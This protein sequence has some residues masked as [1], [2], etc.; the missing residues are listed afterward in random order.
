MRKTLSLCLVIGALSVIGIGILIPRS[1]RTRGSDSASANTK[2]QSAVNLG[3]SETQPIL[4]S[5]RKIA[6]RA[7]RSDTAFP[8]GLPETALPVSPHEELLTLM[9]A[10]RTRPD[11]EQLSSAFK[12]KLSELSVSERADIL[13]KV[14]KIV[15]ERDLDQGLKFLQGLEEFRDRHHFVKAVVEAVAQRDTLRA[16]EWAVRLPDPHLAQSAYNMIGMKSS[17]SDLEASLAWAQGVSDATLRLSAL[18]GVTWTWAQK[19]PKAAYDWAAQLPESEIRDKV[20]V[21][22]AKMISIQDPRRGSEW[23]IQ[24]PEGPGRQEALDYAVFQ[25]AAKDLKTAAEWSVAIQDPQ[26]RENSLVAVARSWSNSDP[27]RASAWAAQLPE[28]QARMSALTTTARKWAEADP[29][30]A[31]Q[32]IDQLAPAPTREEVFKNVTSALA[33]AHPSA[34]EVWLNS[35]LDPNLR[36]AGEQIVS[37]RQTQSRSGAGLPAKP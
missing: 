27:Q 7:P 1:D 21:K 6:P 25:W 16:A 14:G 23:A 20:F 36:K 22:L 12:G 10:A 33:N 37:L 30:G 26:S 19:D 17:Q 24:F 28:G 31:A 29:A 35:V 9:Q 5:S 32:W 34:A 13:E 15:A 18:E 2:A 8:Q 3:D 11:F 4:P